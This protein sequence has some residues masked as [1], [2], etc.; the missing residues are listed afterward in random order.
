M[1]SP[2]REYNTV[3][4]QNWKRILVNI[5]SQLPNKEHDHGHAYLLE[6]KKC[7]QKRSALPNAD[8][9]TIPDRPCKE[10][11]TLTFRQYQF[12]LEIYNTHIDINREAVAFLKKLFPSGMVGLEVGYNQ[13]LTNLIVGRAYDH[14][15]SMAVEPNIDTEAAIQLQLTGYN[16]TYSPSPMGPTVFFQELEHIK[17]QLTQTKVDNTVGKQTAY[18]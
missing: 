8:L 10:V 5:L 18:V 15:V 14:L 3:T 9:P 1:I 13:L 7:F 17:F 16:M 12:Y 2:L 11:T 6:D 4:L